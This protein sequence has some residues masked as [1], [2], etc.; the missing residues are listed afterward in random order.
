[1]SILTEAEQTQFNSFLTNFESPPQQFQPAFSPVPFNTLYNPNNANA[2]VGHLHP[3]QPAYPNPYHQHQHLNQ[4]VSHAHPPYQLK[5]GQRDQQARELTEWMGAQALSGA[6]GLSQLELEH[7]RPTGWDH[8]P[9]ERRK[10]AE[11]EADR[12]DET[13]RRLEQAERAAGFGSGQLSG[14]AKSSDRKVGIRTT[15]HT[16]QLSKPKLATTA[17]QQPKTQPKP[18]PTKPKLEPIYHDRQP[19]AHDYSPPQ[20]DSPALITAPY[21]TPSNIPPSPPGRIRPLPPLPPAPAKLAPLAPTPATQG[22]P[23][24]PGP[25][26]P[27]PALLS[28]QQKKANHIASESRRRAQ[29]RK[30]YDRLVDVVPALRAAVEAEKAEGAASKAAKGKKG[31]KAKKGKGDGGEGEADK[32]DGRSGP[33]SEAVVLTKSKQACH[34]F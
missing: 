34:P 14:R 20:S 1:M 5:P 31:G 29:I 32:M 33:K 2:Y 23:P 27:K 22:S 3:H 15:P 7:D 30:G 26:G 9:A 28:A 25:G 12:A 6:K 10:A 24:P 11:E 13:L 16:V 4:P 21:P 17:N 19:T 18:K 8:S